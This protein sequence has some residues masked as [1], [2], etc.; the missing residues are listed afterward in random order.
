MSMLLLGMRSTSILL[1]CYKK[2]DI[3]PLFCIDDAKV[4][5]MED[6]CIDDV[7]VL[8]CNCNFPCTQCRRNCR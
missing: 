7:V 2:E 4:I 3:I 5:E 6:E 1:N 8:L